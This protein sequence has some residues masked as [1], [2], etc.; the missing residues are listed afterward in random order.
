MRASEHGYADPLALEIANRADAR[1][2]EDLET[3]DVN[4]GEEHDGKSRIDLKKEGRHEGHA[5]IDVARRERRIGIRVGNRNVL[6]ILESF[7]LQ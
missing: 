4:T 3:A 6:D 5:E 7:E 2:P 1:I